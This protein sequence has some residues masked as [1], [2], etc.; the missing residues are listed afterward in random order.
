MEE[1]KINMEVAA[2]DVVFI[3]SASVKHGNLDINS[4]TGETRYSFTM[5]TA[6]SIFSWQSIHKRIRYGK[7]EKKTR[8]RRKEMGEWV[9][10][11]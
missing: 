3:P 11:I 6:G 5:Y 9:G 10:V 4:D 8:R 1:M 2:G 7:S